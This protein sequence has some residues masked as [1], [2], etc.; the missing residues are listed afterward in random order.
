[1]PK[2]AAGAAL[3]SCLFN[4]AL[5]AMID[6]A[7]QPGRV[8]AKAQDVHILSGGL[9]VLL[10]GIVAMGI[11]IGPAMNGFGGMGISVLSIVIIVLY[12]LGGRMIARLEKERMSEVLAQEAQ[13]NAYDS[14][15][16]RQA[17]IVFILSAIGI[18]ALGIW[19]AS[20]GDRLSTTTGLSVSFVGNLFL[21]T[22]TS[23][24]EIAASLAAIR[25][26]A[27]D[28]AIGNVLGSNLFNIALFFVYD[29]AD[30]RANFWAALT[31]ANAFAA[32]MTIMMTGV[33]II[34]LMYRA[35][36]KTP[37]RFSWDGI[38]LAGMYLGSMVMLYLIG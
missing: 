32:V 24:P 29:I 3:G 20:I 27:I 23:L 35:S 19:L 30:G 9:G 17:Y 7:Y 13:E 14:I 34:S 37:Y 1:V 10:L 22:S 8:L 16:A 15:S 18:V 21:A 6:L 25:L 4:L 33:V 2:L 36:P 11:L 38:A 5:I 28:L 26:G 31:N 12:A